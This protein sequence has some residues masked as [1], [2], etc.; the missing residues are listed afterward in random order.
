MQTVCPE[1]PPQMGLLS[2]LNRLTKKEHLVGTVMFWEATKE[3]PSKNGENRQII[4]NQYIFNQYIF[5][6]YNIQ[7]I[8]IHY[9]INMLFLSMIIWLCWLLSDVCITGF[10]KNLFDLNQLMPHQRPKQQVK[11][12]SRVG[13]TWAQWKRDGI[14]NELKLTSC[15]EGRLRRRGWPVV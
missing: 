5:N 9:S 4:F 15:G 14:R 2:L 10:N 8:Y 3:R 6:R 13:A 1:L 12:S 7:S 11:T